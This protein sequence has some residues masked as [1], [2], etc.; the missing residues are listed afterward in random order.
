[1]PASSSVVP[2]ELT[3]LYV[4]LRGEIVTIDATEATREIEAADADAL[5][6]PTIAAAADHV[7]RTAM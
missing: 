1:M 4:S 6:P 5:V 7:A 3:W 2:L